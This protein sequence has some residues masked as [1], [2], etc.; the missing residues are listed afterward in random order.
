[1]GNVELLEFIAIISVLL[2]QFQ[3]SLQAGKS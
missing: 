2:L 3:F 1:M